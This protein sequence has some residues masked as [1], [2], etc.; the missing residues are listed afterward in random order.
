MKK[1]KSYTYIAIL[2]TSIFLA[3]PVNLFAYLDPGSGSYFI[4]I[5]IGAILG[6][7]YAVNVYWTKI[8]SVFKKPDKDENI[9]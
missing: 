5:A 9:K 3:A 2:F 7:F 1:L 6:G 8:K 4:Q